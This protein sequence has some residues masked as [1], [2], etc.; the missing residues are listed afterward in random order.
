MRFLMGHESEWGH[1]GGS[2]P[3]IRPI[4]HEM[5]HFGEVFCP[6]LASR[7]P[8]LA[9]GK[10]EPHAFTEK[11][12]D[13]LD[14]AMTGLRLRLLG[15]RRMREMLRIIGMNAYDLVEEHFESPLV[16]G[17]I[18]PRCR[19]RNRICSPNPGNGDQL[20]CTVWGQN[21]AAG[22]NSLTQ[23]QGRDGQCQ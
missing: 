16:K 18:D 14:L 7:A 9:R 4:I 5:Q 10:D 3:T 21:H 20:L 23:P 2:E 15:R 22:N 1:G 12:C 11:L 8:G 6:L 13:A 19:Y 17:A